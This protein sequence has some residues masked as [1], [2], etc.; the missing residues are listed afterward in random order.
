MSNKPINTLCAVLL[1][2]FLVGCKP[3]V[4][5]Q[6]RIDEQRREHVSNTIQENEVLPK[7]DTTTQTVLKRGGKFF[8]APKEYFG[9][10]G[11]HGF[12]WPS[13]TPKYVS[14]ENYPERVAAKAGKIDS[15]VIA[16]QIESRQIPNDTSAY[17]AEAIANKKLIERRSIREGL[18]R[19]VLQTPSTQYPTEVLY[20][21]TK[22]RLNHIDRSPVIG[23]NDGSSLNAA[24]TSFPWKGQLY[25]Y[26]RFNSTHCK[27]WPEI[28]TEIIRVLNL[29][30]EA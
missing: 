23:C 25:I 19:L 29:V 3:N 18:D 6:A 4:E 9:Q 14:H 15:V 12:Y 22:L 2:L 28:Y 17:L 24:G 11:M 30:K 13:K 10:G 7:I 21:A 20:E 5:Q 26:V 27:D 8:I 1:T 16:F